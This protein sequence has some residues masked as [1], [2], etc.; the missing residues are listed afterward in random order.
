ML[1]EY[2]Q[3]LKETKNKKIGKKIIQ[4]FYMVKKNMANNLKN[5]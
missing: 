2:T 5:H 1:Y 3:K 4:I